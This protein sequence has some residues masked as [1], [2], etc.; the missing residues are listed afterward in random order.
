MI[1]CEIG[2]QLTCC[3]L[4]VKTFDN[5]LLIDVHSQHTDTSAHIATKVVQQSDFCV[6]I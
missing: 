4:L 3:N 1:V 6:T 5:L 2:G